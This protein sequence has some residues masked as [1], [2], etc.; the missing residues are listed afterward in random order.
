MEME[1]TRHK[2]AKQEKQAQSDI[3]NTKAKLINLETSLRE[4]E[5]RFSDVSSQLDHA[6]KRVEE[7]T[8]L[9]Q[10]IS[11][12][13]ARI[14]STICS[15]TTLLQKLV[16][17]VANYRENVAL[18]GEAAARQKLVVQEAKQKLSPFN[19]PFFK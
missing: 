17:D 14:H 13:S 6:V 8:A 15:S 10:D 3:E 9:K 1:D 5:Q 4:Q 11:D 16:I 2:L 18:A 19:H 12:Q 7:L